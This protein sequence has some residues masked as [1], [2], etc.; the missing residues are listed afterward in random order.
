MPVPQVPE[1]PMP[2]PGE[3]EESGMPPM[4]PGD[5]GSGMPPMPPPMMPGEEESGMPP[6]MPGEEESGMMPP[7]MSGDDMGMM[8]PMPTPPPVNPMELFENSFTC[9]ERGCYVFSCDDETG[10]CINAIPMEVIEDPR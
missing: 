8:P 7:M 9:D 6:M 1:E 3:E 2:N 4:M 10:V 5:E